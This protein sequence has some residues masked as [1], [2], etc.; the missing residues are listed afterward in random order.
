[1]LDVMAW[2]TETGHGHLCPSVQTRKQQWIDGV[3]G[4][5]KSFVGG[6]VLLMFLLLRKK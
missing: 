2:S 5:H 6:A 3:L 1:M 4:D